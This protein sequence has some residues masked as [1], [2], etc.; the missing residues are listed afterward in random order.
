MKK[1][2]T[3]QQNTTL[4]EQTNGE[5]NIANSVIGYLNESTSQLDAQTL[6]QLQQARQKA[7]SL[8]AARQQ[9]ANAANGQHSNVLSLLG[10]YYAHHRS[11]MSLAL[12]VAAIVLT[13]VIA[14]KFSA[15]N[16][17]GSEGSDAFLLASELPPEAYLDKGFDAWLKHSS[18]Q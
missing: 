7:V 11:A 3:T 15:Q 12:V 5:T 9:P 17:A 18:Q 16:H 8:L 2:P 6:N 10:D 1:E 4:L 14:Q 13:F